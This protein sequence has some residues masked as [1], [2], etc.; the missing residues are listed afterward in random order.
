MQ[1]DDNNILKQKIKYYFE[2]KLPVHI[3]LRST[4]F[5]NGKILEFAGDMIIIEDNLL[6]ATPV[7]FDEI[8]YVEPFRKKEG[9]KR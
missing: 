2:N 9:G 1:G 8:K 6:G 5:L 4:R 3:S 7:Y